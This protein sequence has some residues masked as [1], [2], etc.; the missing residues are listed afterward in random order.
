MIAF[1]PVPSTYEL[2]KKNIR[3]NQVE[4][5]VTPIRRAV[6]SGDA[7]QRIYL[8][9]NHSGAATL[10]MNSL[11]QISSSWID[12]E[13]INKHGLDELDIRDN[14]PIFIKVDVEG[15]EIEALQ[16][17]FASKLEPQICEIFR[18]I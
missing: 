12:I 7:S 13:I 14:L 10:S 9:E 1:E 11:S 3:L 16:E 6:S 8:S 2:M 5:I 18:G 17:V 15:H 4:S